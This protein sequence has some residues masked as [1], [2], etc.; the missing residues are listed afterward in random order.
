M[1]LRQILQDKDKKVK[2]MKSKV[3]ENEAEMQYLVDDNNKLHYKHKK[4]KA[5]SR[6]LEETVTVLTA[7]YQKYYEKNS[8]HKQRLQK[9]KENFSLLMESY[10]KLEHDHRKLE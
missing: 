3:S 7:K 4:S 5:L 2:V 1:D 9:E 8:K 10:K 6:E